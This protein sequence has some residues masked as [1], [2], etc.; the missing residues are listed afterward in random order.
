MGFIEVVD[1][2][3]RFGK[4]VALRGVS[5]S[6]REGELFAIL[7]P[8]G[9]GKT[10]LL[11]VIAGFEQPDEGRVLI[12]GQDVTD[13]PP[14]K[15][16]TVMV[17]Q[18]WALWPHMTVYENIAFGLKLRKLPK[19]EIE[20]RVR[21]VLELL[22]LKGL[23]N[24]YPSQLSGGQQQRV[25]LARA[26]VVK[27]RVLLLDEPLSNLDA[28]LRLKL[29][30]ELR[31][32]QRQLGITMVY[33]THDQEEAMSLADRI[34]VMRDGR[35]EQVGTPEE[36][37]NKPATLFTAVFLGRTS[38]VTGKVVDVDGDKA[39]VSLGGNNLVR[40]VNHGL[41][42]GDEAAVA[43]KA[44]GA[45]VTKPS[46]MEYYTSIR[47]KVT[48]SMYLGSF[49]EIRLALPGTGQEILLDL[50]VEEPLPKPGEEV[51]A[52]VPL[53]NVHAFPIE[54]EVVRSLKEQA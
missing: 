3:K 54:E 31:K 28:K 24:R 16:G 14:D 48:V 37:Y 8:S 39:I 50:P 45:R 2:H 52:Y 38:L 47:G 13:L 10:T 46:K 36:L 27:P 33:V 18:N 6:I 42:P 12:G 51:E 22:G 9:C 40:A 5:L 26:L 35:V 49:N 11:R 15:R 19:T 41:S 53:R 32:L 25:A 4:T 17:F 20:E 44:D 1:V 34:A 21:W 29:R 23:E 7:G 43:V 30:A